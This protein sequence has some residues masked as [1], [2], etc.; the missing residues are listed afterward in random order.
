MKKVLTL[1][2]ALFA[3]P[4]VADEPAKKDEPQK[5]GAQGT[6][7][8][9]PPPAATG[10]SPL[11]AASKRSGRKGKKP[12][13]V[14]TNETLKQPKNAHITTTNNPGPAP[15]QVDPQIAINRAKREKAAKE[16]ADKKA[17]AAEQA[18]KDK[19]AKQRRL[20][21]AAAA[22]ESDYVDPAQSEAALAEAAKEAAKTEEKKPPQQ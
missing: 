12:A 4:L 17:A 2:L 7:L 11:V 16:I 3:L 21:A 10:D 20:A 8:T 22:A 13:N 14:I 1:T 6:V 15:Y 9:P 18:L 5:A 19:D